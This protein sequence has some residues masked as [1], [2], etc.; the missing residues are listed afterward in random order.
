[1]SAVSD[2]GPEY[3]PEKAHAETRGEALRAEMP[4]IAMLLGAFVGIAINDFTGRQTILY[5]QLLAPAYA[6]ICIIVGWEQGGPTASRTRL[7]RTQAIHW[8]ACFLAMRL[9]FLPQVRGVLNDNATGLSLLTVLALSTFLA[10]LHSSIWRISA[11]GILLA[12]AVPGAAWL[13]QSALLLSAE[14]LLAL[15]LGALFFWVRSKMR[16]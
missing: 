1:V 11:V 5:W 4:Y 16:K 6:L 10:G 14:A 9:L 7:V 2:I 8:L 12:L 13:E 3:A 15:G